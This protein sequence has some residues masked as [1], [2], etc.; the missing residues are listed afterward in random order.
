MTAQYNPEN[1]PRPQIVY[2]EELTRQ[3]AHLMEISDGL[4]D[5]NRREN[6]LIEYMS[7]ADELKAQR[8]QQYTNKGGNLNLSDF[9]YRQVLDNLKNVD[10]LNRPQETSL[11][12]LIKSGHDVLDDD[13]SNIVEKNQVAPVLDWAENE[14]IYA[15]LRLVAS[16]VGKRSGSAFTG[17]VDRDDHF[18]NGVIGLIR[19]IPKFD[20]TKGFK[21]STYASWWIKQSIERSEA[22]DAHLIRLPHRKNT[23]NKLISIEMN[24]LATGKIEK[25]TVPT[26]EWLSMQLGISPED[27]ND[28]LMI[29]TQQKPA[30][31]LD[32]TFGSDTDDNT[33]SLYDIISEEV[34]STE[35]KTDQI[36][37][38][39]QLEQLMSALTE[40]E[41][42][43]L[44]LRFGID[45]GDPKTLDEVAQ[46]LGVSRERIRQIQVVAFE[47][48]NYYIS[49]N[50]PKDT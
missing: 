31:S 36:N 37:S 50:K 2:N 21:F 32:S 17:V 3:R 5:P 41:A 26:V 24:N 34:D 29:Y 48:I 23:I 42:N 13:N 45:S 16:I 40:R 44:K 9:S 20:W 19:S 46:I 43:I 18:N 25:G 22:N 35:H 15:N 28:A 49:R 1:E 30:K 14:A 12:F 6:S 39:V 11:F 47:K 7:V 27:A 8:T 33:N 38:G 4:M 10:L